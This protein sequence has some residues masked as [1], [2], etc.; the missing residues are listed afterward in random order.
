M[1]L[2]FVND[3]E[4]QEYKI[5]LLIVD[6]F[7][8]YLTVVPLHSKTIADVLEGIKTGFAN[9]G[10]K[11]ETVYSDDEGALN[12]KEIQAYFNENNIKHIVSRGHA[13]VAERSIRTI[14]D[15]IY[16]RIDN[17]DQTQW[18]AVLPNALTIYNYKMPHRSTKFTP[19]DARQKKNKKKR[20]RKYQNWKGGK[21]SEERDK[22][23]RPV[24]RVFVFR[25]RVRLVWSSGPTHAI[26]QRLHLLCIP[27]GLD[28][29]RPRWASLYR[30]D[31]AGI[32]HLS[33]RIISRVRAWLPSPNR[34]C[35]ATSIRPPSAD[36][37]RSDFRHQ[38][39]YLFCRKT[40]QTIVQTTVISLSLFLFLSFLLRCQQQIPLGAEAINR[41]GDD[42]K[43]TDDI[44]PQGIDNLISS[45]VLWVFSTYRRQ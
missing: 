19:A 12:S 18:T 5:G 37:S 25:R 29:C 26:V 40:K 17:S 6:I 4:N 32:P 36:K 41:P 27:C 16:R 22:R 7:S 1:D 15:L 31:P 2:F 33:V 14:K 43:I 24:F 34:C 35:S 23:T 3:L 28:L 11:P 39:S 45:F 38:S 30:E 13:P 9:M 10:G 44:H 20:Q 21:Q 8:K 42:G